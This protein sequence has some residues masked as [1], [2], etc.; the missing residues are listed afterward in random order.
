MKRFA[1]LALLV[2]VVALNACVN[3]PAQKD[4]TAILENYYGVLPQPSSAP[5]EKPRAVSR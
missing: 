1:G 2:F 4:S 3:D 5:T